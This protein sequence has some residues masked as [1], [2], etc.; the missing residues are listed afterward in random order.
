MNSLALFK[1]NALKKQFDITFKTKLKLSVLKGLGF[2]LY[3]NSKLK[4]YQL[5]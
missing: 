4:Q 2:E 1:I 3:G 5:K